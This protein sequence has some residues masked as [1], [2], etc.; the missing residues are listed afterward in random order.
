VACGDDMNA[1]KETVLRCSPADAEVIFYTMYYVQFFAVLT[2]S[3]VC[4]HVNDSHNY[5]CYLILFII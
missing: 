5:Y 4:V 1:M 2:V 3:V